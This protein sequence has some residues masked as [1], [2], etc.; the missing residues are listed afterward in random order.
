MLFQRIHQQLTAV[1]HEAL[2]G[3]FVARDGEEIQVRQTPH[4]RLSTGTEWHLLGLCLQH[5]L[6]RRRQRH[7]RCRHGG[8]ATLL[9]LLAFAARPLFD[10]VVVARAELF[11]QRDVV[12]LRSAT[13]VLILSIV[14][15]RQNLWGLHQ[16]HIY[17]WVIDKDLSV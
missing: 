13:F 2:I 7:C 8:L 15:L 14:N 1:A 9:A 4:A 11:V 17:R 10:V 5:L 3:L 6:G 12:E 16:S